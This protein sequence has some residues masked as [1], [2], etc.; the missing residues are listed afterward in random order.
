MVDLQ[1][2]VTLERL[3]QIFTAVESVH[4]KQLGDP[5]V[6]SPNHAIGFLRAWLDHA[7]FKASTFGQ[8]HG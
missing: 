3:L 4:F 8:I 7:M 1:S 6:E 2:P 5:S